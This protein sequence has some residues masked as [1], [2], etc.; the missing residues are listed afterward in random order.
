MSGG[1]QV[2]VEA[3]QA[4]T[5]RHRV[6]GAVQGAVD[7]GRLLGLLTETQK[8]SRCFVVARAFVRKSLSAK[9]VLQ[10]AQQL[11]G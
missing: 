6:R 4:L 2:E 3:K 5:A 1:G 11:R 10:H 9:P 7:G 8:A